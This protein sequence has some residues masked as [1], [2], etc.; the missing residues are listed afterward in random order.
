MAGRSALERDQVLELDAVADIAV[1]KMAFV[2]DSA[3][4]LNIGTR[5]SGKIRGHAE[6]HGQRR[7]D[8]QGQRTAH[9]E[10]GT[11]NV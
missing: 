9:E 10:A 11:G 3:E 4:T 6:G 5:A 1:G 2:D 8:S 7:A